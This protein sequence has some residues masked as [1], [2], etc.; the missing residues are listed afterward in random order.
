MFAQQI[1]HDVDRSASLLHDVHISGEFQQAHPALNTKYILTMPQ[2][3]QQ[4]VHGYLASIA[5]RPCMA[6]QATCP[7]AA[8]QHIKNGCVRASD[9]QPSLEVPGKTG[10][11][12]GEYLLE[13]L[14][15]NLMAT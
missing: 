11:M 12:Q 15:M 3:A 9:A 8:S 1:P 6:L 5:A 2:L 13:P 7:L 10:Q 14:G 4:Q